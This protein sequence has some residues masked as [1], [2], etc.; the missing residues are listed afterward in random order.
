[1]VLEDA[2][3]AAKRDATVYGELLGY[4]SATGV[5]HE[6]L[7]ACTRVL[8]GC[9]RRAL[10]DAACEPE[11]IDFI[12]L[13]GDA[14]PGGDA[15]ET[16]A[17]MEALGRHGTQIPAT[18]VKSATGHLGNASGSIELALMFEAMQRRTLLPIVNLE[19]P[20][21]VLPLSF[22]TKPTEDLELRRGLLLNRGWPSHYT[23][24]VVGRPDV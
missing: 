24:L 19:D 21:P 13:S 15:V 5:P 12:H 16:R 23:A 20:D 2:E 14:T 22:V 9:I 6:D 18:T 17:T 7:A 1:M 4:G 10:D 11:E 3:A 8:T